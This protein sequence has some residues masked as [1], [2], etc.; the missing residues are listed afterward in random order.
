[1]EEGRKVRKPAPPEMYTNV[2]WKV[3][4]AVIPGATVQASF[5]TRVADK[6]PVKTDKTQ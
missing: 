1:M 3:T 6:A 5:Q 2:R 4:G